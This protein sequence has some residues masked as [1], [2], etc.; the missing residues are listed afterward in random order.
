MGQLN[1]RRLTMSAQAK[2][3]WLLPLFSP[4]NSD[5]YSS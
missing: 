2:K 5:Q 4:S 3:D 1:G